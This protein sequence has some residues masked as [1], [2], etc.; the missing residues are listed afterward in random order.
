MKY[1]YQQ[2]FN[3]ISLQKV[4]DEIQLKNLTTV[5]YRSSNYYDRLKKKLQQNF[6]YTVRSIKYFLQSINASPLS[7]CKKEVCVSKLHSRSVFE[8]AIISK[9]S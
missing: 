1:L 2:L 4:E 9:R 5:H 7:L 6:S 8:Q 3:Y